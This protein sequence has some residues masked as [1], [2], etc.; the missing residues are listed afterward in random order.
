M[1]LQRT[2][3]PKKDMPTEA[4]PLVAGAASGEKEARPSG[5]KEARPWEIF[6]I[7]FPVI[8]GYVIEFYDYGAYTMLTHELE[9]NL[10]PPNISGGDDAIANLRRS[11]AVW[12]VFTLGQVARPVG[13]ALIGV[14]ADKFGRKP[15]VIAATVG[16]WV[17]T[18]GIGLIP[19]ARCCGETWG[20]VGYTLLC[21]LRMLQGACAAGGVAIAYTYAVE[22]TAPRRAGFAICLICL[23]GNV[24]HLSASAVSQ[25]FESLLD[26]PQMLDWGWRLPFLLSLPLGLTVTWLQSKLA[27]TEVFR[28]VASERHAHAADR[29]SSKKGPDA[30]A[31]LGG[32]F[33][34]LLTSYRLEFMVAFLLS[35]FTASMQYGTYSYLK[36]YLQT[37]DA[38]GSAEGACITTFIY[39]MTVPTDLLAGF[40]ADS[41]GMLRS[42]LVWY[43]VAITLTLPAWVLLS[44]RA[45]LG[46]ALIGAAML[47]VVFTGREFLIGVSLGLF[48]PEIRVTGFGLAYNLAQMIFGASAPLACN[49][50]WST[51]T[52]A[53]RDETSSP[54]D[55]GYPALVDAAPAIWVY[56]SLLLCAVGL[57]ALV[58]ANQSGVLERVSHIRDER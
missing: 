15:M 26:D 29:E 43:V 49:Y 24:G 14:L 9:A 39:L 1:T 23:S 55:L 13:G 34:R 51:L 21:F 56:Q 16:M 22:V 50:I 25:L 45:D 41:F 4:T 6:L 11:N 52:D 17:G 40:I 54:T 8:L 28:N 18:L 37:I 38:R 30:P 2:G 32:I 35:T 19:T 12:L 42:A 36:D 47:A 31:P 58:C 3:A 44:T 48:P 27:E 33:Y 10:F 7:I 5:E 57:L 46:T 53:T 20:M